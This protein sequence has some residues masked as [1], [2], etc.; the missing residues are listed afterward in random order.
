MCEF[1]KETWECIEG[2]LL[3]RSLEQTSTTLLAE[4]LL[5]T[6]HRS[7]LRS[8]IHPNPPH[9]HHRNLFRKRVFLEPQMMGW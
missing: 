2:D 9:L 8:F 3:I 5:G 6:L 7:H 4:Q 1:L